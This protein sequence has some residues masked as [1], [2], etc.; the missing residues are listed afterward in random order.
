[1]SSLCLLYISFLLPQPL[2]LYS[3]TNLHLQA[4]PSDA[5]PAKDVHFEFLL[6]EINLQVFI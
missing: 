5:R 4:A 2:Q 3:L 1:M 6:A